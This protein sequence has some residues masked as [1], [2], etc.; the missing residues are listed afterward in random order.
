MQRIDLNNKTILVTGSPGFIGANLVIRLLKEMSGGTVVSLDNMND[1]YDPALKE[2]RLG[3]PWPCGEGS[4]AVSREA[5][6]C[7]RLHRR[8]GSG[9]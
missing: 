1:Y 7:E 5:C 6:I 4:G 8:Q 2:Y 3:P 9:G